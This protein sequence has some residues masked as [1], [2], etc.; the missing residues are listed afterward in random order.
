MLDRRVHQS[1]R[2]RFYGETAPDGFRVTYGRCT[3]RYLDSDAI[4]PGFA[5]PSV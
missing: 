1:Q 3:A 5:A 4:P 2:C